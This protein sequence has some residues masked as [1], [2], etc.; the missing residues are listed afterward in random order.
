VAAALESIHVQ[1]MVELE[2]VAVALTT[3][4]RREEA[5]GLVE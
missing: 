5:L 4:V 3:L 1:E 2:E